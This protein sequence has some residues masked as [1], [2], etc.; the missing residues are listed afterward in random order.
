MVQDDQ[1]N[2]LFVFVMTT[3]KNLKTHYSILH[4][5]KQMTDEA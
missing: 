4:M 3:H 1:L 5:S 2:G